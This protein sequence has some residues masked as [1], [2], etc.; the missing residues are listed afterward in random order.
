M[1]KMRFRKNVDIRQATHV[2][3]SGRIEK[4]KIKYGVSADGKSVLPPSQG[5]FGVITE[6]NRTV[7]MWEAQSYLAENQN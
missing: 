4:I 6:S 2:S 7:T 1:E 5:G 3:Y